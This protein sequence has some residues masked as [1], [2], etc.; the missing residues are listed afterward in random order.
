[1]LW[2]ETTKTEQNKITHSYT[3]ARDTTYKK[4][5]NVDTKLHNTSPLHLGDPLAVACVVAVGHRCT[6]PLY[7]LKVH[8]Q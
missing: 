3:R 2:H 4:F 8:S 7:R 6:R 1:M 5:V